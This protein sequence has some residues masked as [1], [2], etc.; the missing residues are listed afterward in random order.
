MWITQTYKS[1]YLL[2][3]QVFMSADPCSE[4][5][6]LSH[7][8]CRAHSSS[9]G[10]I[11]QWSALPGYI[12]SNSPQVRQ[13]MFTLTGDT[14]V[15]RFI[16]IATV[17]QF[18]AKE[19]TTRSGVELPSLFFTIVHLYSF[20]LQLHIGSLILLK[21]DKSYQNLCVCG[22]TTDVSDQSKSW[23]DMLAE[24]GLFNLLWLKKRHFF[25]K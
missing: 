25:I 3:V 7:T 15:Y 2:Y 16:L 4:V 24:M 1:F 18:V 10:W 8:G 12:I 14:I 6:G 9:C 19:G 5:W 20:P 11:S 13:P 17:W 21:L 22:Q 23:E